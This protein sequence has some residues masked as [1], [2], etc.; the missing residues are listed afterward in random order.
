MVNWFCFRIHYQDATVRIGGNQEIEEYKT[1]KNL[2]L[3]YVLKTYF[4]IFKTLV[5]FHPGRY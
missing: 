3:K 4:Q 1:I 5:Y 2:L